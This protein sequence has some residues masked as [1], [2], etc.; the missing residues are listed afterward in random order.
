LESGR[1]RTARAGVDGHETTLSVIEPVALLGIEELLGGHAHDATLS[2]LRPSTVRLVPHRALRAAMDASPAIAYEVFRILATD[3][4][5]ANERHV[6]MNT[7]DVRQ[8]L[9]LWLRERA[10]NDVDRHAHPDARVVIDRTQGELADELWTTR[11]TLNRAIHDLEL[12]GE[13][14]LDGNVIVMHRPEVA[15]RASERSR[16]PTAFPAAPQPD[17]SRSA[18]S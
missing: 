1:L 6:R 4:R 18:P 11:S 15:Q 9:L 12:T 3:L 5:R 7:C 16:T 17:S 14:R 10:V 8:R 2:A 13:I